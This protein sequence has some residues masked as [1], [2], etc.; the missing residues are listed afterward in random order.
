MYAESWGPI[1]PWLMEIAPHLT[2]LLAAKPMFKWDMFP[3]I[4][5]PLAPKA[6][7][8]MGSI[9]HLAFLFDPFKHVT[10]TVLSSVFL[11]GEISPDGE[12]FFQKR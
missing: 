12:F 5:S 11:R 2:S 6:S 1:K 4:V 9:P 7:T 3:I 10:M 8:Y